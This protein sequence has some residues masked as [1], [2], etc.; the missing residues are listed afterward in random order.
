MSGA[1]VACELLLL[2]HIQQSSQEP[3]LEIQKGLD[4]ICQEFIT[5]HTETV[6][7]LFRL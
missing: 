5:E 3:I 6:E 1:P 7:V 4:H 2:L